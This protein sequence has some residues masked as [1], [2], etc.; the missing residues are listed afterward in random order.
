MFLFLF[1]FYF[2]SYSFLMSIFALNYMY[3]IEVP[4]NS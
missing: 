2:C 4:E 1:K 3:Q